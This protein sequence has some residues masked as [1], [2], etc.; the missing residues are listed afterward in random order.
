M[1][2]GQQAPAVLGGERV[3]NAIPMATFTIKP[4]EAFDFAKPHEWEKWIRRLASNLNS[5]TEENQMNTLVYCMGDEA[6]DVLRGLELTNEQRQQYSAVKKGFDDYFIPKKNVIYERAKFN[7]RVQQ[8]SE[9][10]DVFLTSLYALAESCEYCQLHDELLRDRLVVGLK[11]SKLSERMQLDRELTLTKAITMA[12]QSEEV[13]RQ[14]TDLRGE[15]NTASKVSVDALNKNRGKLPYAKQF[16]PKGQTQGNPKFNKMAPSATELKT[17]H[18][19]GKSPPHPAVQCPAK[20]AECHICHKRGHYGRTC[21]LANTVNEVAE[22][23]DGLFLGVVSSGDEPWMADIDL[24]GSKVTFKIDTGADVTAI[25]E[26]VYKTLQRGDE[27][28]DRALKQLYGPGGANLTVLGSATETLTYKERS[29]T[30]KIYIVKDL[31]MGLLSRP[32]SVRLKLVARVD[33]IDQETTEREK[34]WAGA[35]CF[36]SRHRARDLGKLSPGDNVWI[37]DAAEQGKVTSVHSS[38]RSYLVMGPQGTLRRNRCHLIPMPESGSDC[39][40]QPEQPPEA[41]SGVETPP[42]ATESVNTPDIRRSGREIKK[43]DRLNL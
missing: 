3:A 21:R 2:D 42:P 9:T 19:C 10:V 15:L 31:H 8:P 29:I 32:A 22:D 39:E 34:R 5:S 25:P 7:K 14:Q 13:K 36:N 40:Q 17:C 20:S 27:K 35:K 4:P 26:Q 18:K 30:E 41:D 1:E 37:S 12:R 43:P 6:D 16:K 38:P 23:M 28:P 11:D 24:K 33:T